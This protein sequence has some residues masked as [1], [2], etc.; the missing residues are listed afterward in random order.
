MLD[1]PIDR[2]WQN[3]SDCCTSIFDSASVG[4]DRRVGRLLEVKLPIHGALRFA[5]AYANRVEEAIVHRNDG[6]HCSGLKVNGVN[7]KR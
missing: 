3:N 4:G 7:V 2:S 1:I 6:V 5:L